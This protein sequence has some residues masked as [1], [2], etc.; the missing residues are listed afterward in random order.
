MSEV[1][2][3]RGDN[4]AMAETASTPSAMLAQALAGNAAPET[5]ERLFDLQERWQ[6]N[7]ARMAFDNAMAELR[8]DMPTVY[9]T[10]K[11]HGYMYEQ[12]ADITEAVS[13]YMAPLGLSFRWRTES[14]ERAVKVTCII[15]HRNGH[16]EET[17]L[18]HM[19]DKTGS[20][21]DIQALGSVVTYLQRYTLKAAIGIAAAKDDDGARQ[22]QAVKPNQST[23]AQIPKSQAREVYAELQADI[24]ASGDEET[25]MQWGNDRS[26]DLKSLPDDWQAELRKRFRSRL[27]ELR[28]EAS[29]QEAREIQEIDCDQPPF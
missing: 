11:G 16:F 22:A 6:A 19:P 4:T 25:L 17:S 21:N 10:T 5:L 23:T 15:S 9:K 2:D 24:D 26:E 27:D 28:A 12:L 3:L 8:H 13:P 14:N 29:E 20:K 7:Q 18:I 1:I